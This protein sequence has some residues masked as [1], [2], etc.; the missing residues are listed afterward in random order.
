[1]R[2]IRLRQAGACG[3]TPHLSPLPLP[4]GRGDWRSLLPEIARTFLSALQDLQIRLSE[5]RHE[6]APLVS[7][8]IMH[9]D[10]T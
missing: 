2:V 6:V 4:K 5:S 7:T 10:C 1:V 9:H 3:A 8:R